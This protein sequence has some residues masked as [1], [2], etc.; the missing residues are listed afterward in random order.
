MSTNPRDLRRAQREKYIVSVIKELIDEGEF[1]DVPA[2]SIAE[3]YGCSDSFIRQEL[4]RLR[5]KGHIEVSRT[6]GPAKLYWP[7]ENGDQLLNHD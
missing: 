5:E 7:V 2:P 3:E 1:A 6:V 4:R